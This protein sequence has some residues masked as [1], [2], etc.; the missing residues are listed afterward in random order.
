MT[1]YVALLRGINVAGHRQVAMADLRDLLGHLGLLDA[2]SLLQSGN[3]V[4]RAEAQAG[5]KLERLLETAAEKRL[6]LKTD[7]IVRSARE[8][9]GNIAGNPFRKE[10]ES[11]PGRLV[12]MFF[13]GSPVSGGIEAL[14]AAN[15]GPEVLRARGTH[16]YIVYPNGMGRS[17]FTTALIEKKLGTRGTAR[18]WNTVRKIGALL[19]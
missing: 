1:S 7:F 19:P 2:T 6:G 5:A 14:E 13:K 3:L 10:A 11:D 15:D 4:F 16:V 12:V 17:R 18:N 8:W 9:D